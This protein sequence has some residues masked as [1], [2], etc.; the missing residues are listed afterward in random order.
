MSILFALAIMTMPAD[1]RKHKDPDVT[2]GVNDQFQGIMSPRNQPTMT[3]PLWERYAFAGKR[4]LE[5]R[6]IEMSQ[7]FYWAACF[8]LEDVARLGIIKTFD[9]TARNQLTDMFALSNDVFFQDPHPADISDTP[10][11]FAQK[12]ETDEKPRVDAEMGKLLDEQNSFDKKHPNFDGGARL[13]MT[14]L[15]RRIEFETRLLPLM[16]KLLGA[17]DTVTSIVR[18]HLNNDTREMKDVST[19]D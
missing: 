10:A 18:D 12:V 3:D 15:R 5:R 1:A 17:D 11:A 7:R 13:R 9:D 19:Q 14:H 6:D 16:I 2:P 8:E 4:M